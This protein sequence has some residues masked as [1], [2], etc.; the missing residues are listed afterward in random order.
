MKT[1]QR[2]L[3]RKKEKEHVQQETTEDMYEEKEAKELF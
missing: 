3:E 2:E 1:Q